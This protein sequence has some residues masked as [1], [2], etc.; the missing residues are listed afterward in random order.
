MVYLDNNA[1]TPL[2]PAVIE[3]M[4]WFMGGHF[5]NPSSLYPIGREVKNLINEA[6]AHVAAAVGAAKASIYFTG[7][8]TESDNQAI[9]G[10][11]DA[12][13]DKREFVT[14]TIE[15]PAVSQTAA[16]LEGKGYKVTYVPVDA[17]GTIDLDALRSAVTPQTALVSVMHANNEIGTI[18]PIEDVVRIARE[19]GA[20]VHTDAVQSFGK[21]PFRADDLGVDLLTVSAHKIYG[22]KGAGALYVRKG[23][24]L[25]PFIHGGH[26]ER[27]LRA[28]T[29]NTIGIIGFGEAARI[30]PLHFEADSAR[31]R[32]L[33]G[34]LK[35]GLEAG[36]P[37]IHF[38]G[39]PV[40]RIPTTLSYAFLGLESEAILLSLAA[41]GIYVSTGSACSEESEDVS[42][43]LRA[44][45]LRPEFARSTVRMSLGRFNTDDDVTEILR[46]LPEVVDKLR[47]ISPWDP[48]EF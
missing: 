22:P 23:T 24:P 41:Q 19:Q 10:V 11:I 46:V 17:T 29:E 33:A 15:H 3:K 7:S 43:V 20:L 31:L 34:R 4:A 25:R 14:T 12:L 32:R 39:H 8:G 35:D 42:P 6:R 21:I 38:N 26:Q 28:G 18:Q 13:P 44:I 47:K 37:K 5:G 16:Y 40:N 45:G 36:V 30:L 9:L 27:G 2:D 1:T 48:E